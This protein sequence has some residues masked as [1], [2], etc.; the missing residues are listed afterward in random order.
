MCAAKVEPPSFTEL[1]G[2]YKITEEVCQKKISDRHL[3]SI[4]SSCCEEW[5]SLPPYLGLETMVAHDISKGGGSESKKRC[6][7]L[8]KWRHIKG[9]RATYQSLIVALLDMKCVDDAEEVCRI[10]RDSIS[11][12]PQQQEEASSAIPTQSSSSV[13]IG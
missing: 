6:D 5:E 10:L 4:S 1:L 8:F 12:Q 7:F 3:S 11:S 9:S 13:S 2:T